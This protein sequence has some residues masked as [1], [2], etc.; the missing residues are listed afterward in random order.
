MFRIPPAHRT[1]VRPTTL[2][3]RTCE[4]ERRRT[5]GI[6]RCWTEH[7]AR[8][9]LFGTLDRASRRWQRLTIS[10]GEITHLDQLRQQLGLDPSP[11]RQTEQS[12][13][14]SPDVA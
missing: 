14:T 11:E 4:A 3:E 6:P 7:S 9:L 13:E 2:L 12:R 8:T 5:K 1:F 10:E